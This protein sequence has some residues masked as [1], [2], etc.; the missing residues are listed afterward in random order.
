[1]QGGREEGRQG[2]LSA[3]R[4][5]DST[6]AGILCTG[7]LEFIY[8]IFPFQKKYRKGKPEIIKE[9]DYVQGVGI[10]E[11]D[12]GESELSKYTFFE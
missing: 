11:M 6:C 1:M 12:R 9:T 2:T 3:A 10:C 8:K 4:P 7:L 5:R